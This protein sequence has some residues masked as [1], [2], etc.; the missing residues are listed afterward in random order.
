MN[1]CKFCKLDESKVIFRGKNWA[2]LFHKQD[3]LGRCILVTNRH[4][5]NFS[6]L[7][8]D[9]VIDLRNMLSALESELKDLYDCTMLNWSCNMNNTFSEDSPNP[10]VHIHIRPRYKNRVTINEINYIDKE[11]GSHYDRNAT[12]QFDDKTINLIYEQIKNNFEK[13]YS[14]TLSDNK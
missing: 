4:V 9:E 2:L 5:N 1:N 11:F 12:I 7:N 10:H 6:K 13:Y 14:V 3:Y 8:D